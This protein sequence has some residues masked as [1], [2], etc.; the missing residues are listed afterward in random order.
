MP[1]TFPSPTYPTQPYPATQAILSRLYFVSPIPQMTFEAKSG[2][3]YTSDVNGKISPQPITLGDSADLLN[4]GCIPYVAPW[5]G[6][7]LGA[8]MNL[9][10]SSSA[11]DDQPIILNVPTGVGVRITKITA[12]NASHT[13]ATAV[14]G[15]Y[16]ASAQ[17][18]TA[19]VAA[20]QAYT[21]LTVAST[22]SL[23][24]TLV[25]SGGPPTPANTV[26]TDQVQ[27][28]LNLSTAEGAAATADFYV[29]GD[30]YW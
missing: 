15:I 2:N 14:G 28:Y 9:A 26:W 29:F 11:A 25:A 24:L 18:G 8:N 22:E 1:I 12:T 7:L 3:T 16:S 5:I 4:A 13:L 10:G 27:F 21:G 20:A 6:R 30:L 17:G 19:L 23:D